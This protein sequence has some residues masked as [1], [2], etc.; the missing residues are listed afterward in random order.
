M[1]LVPVAEDVEKM[2]RLFPSIENVSKH[3]RNVCR[4]PAVLKLELE[5]VFDKYLHCC[6]ANKG[7]LFTE[8]A[9]GLMERMLKR[10]ADFR[11]SGE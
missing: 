3:V 1:L 11:L 7:E 6:D 4:E 8:A 10:V 2:K 5:K 9:L